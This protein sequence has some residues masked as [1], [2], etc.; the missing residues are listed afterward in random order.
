MKSRL[1]VAIAVLGCTLSDSLFAARPMLTDDAR[2]VDEGRCQLESWLQR[3]G[4]SSEW[5]ALPACSGGRS[6]E[7]ALGAQRNTATAPSPDSAYLLQY[8]RVWRDLRP[9]DFGVAL[10]LGTN[11]ADG[12]IAPYVVA[13]IS[14]ANSNERSF[15]H[16]NLGLSRDKERPRF[17][18][19]WGLAAEQHLA[20]D[21]WLIAERYAA[22]SEQ[23]LL[24]VGLRWWVEHEV[25][26]ID[27]TMSRESAST[28][29]PLR[30][31]S[32]GLRWI[33]DDPRKTGN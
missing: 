10:N 13:P 8:K 23:R 5:W 12:R 14:W 31:F 1:V 19:P 33:F 3:N 4:K 17:N 24:Q 2:T 25:L 21:L 18:R 28:A 26:Q 32:L 11:Q 20:T 29:R 16:A 27:A 30:Q 6:V 7:W 15:L 9:S 22:S